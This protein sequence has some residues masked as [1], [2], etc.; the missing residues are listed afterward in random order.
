MNK[1]YSTRLAS[2]ASSNKN[3]IPFFLFAGALIVFLCSQNIVFMIFSDTSWP[4]C[5]L[6]SITLTEGLALPS[7][8][9]NHN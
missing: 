2:G 1:F 4:T 6:R 9:H 8:L 7:T 5:M 3:L